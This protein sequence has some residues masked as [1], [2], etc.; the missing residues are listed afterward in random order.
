MAT[1][2]LPSDQLKAAWIRAAEA[3]A[4]INQWPEGMK[5]PYMGSRVNGALHSTVVAC[6]PQ[7]V[8]GT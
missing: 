1:H 3:I 8:R 4:T 6:A 5:L 2:G 7:A